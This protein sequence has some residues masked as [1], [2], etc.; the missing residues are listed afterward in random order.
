MKRSIWLVPLVAVVLVA[1]GTACGGDRRA[2]RTTETDG[3]S[4]VSE[5]SRKSTEPPGSGPTDESAGTDPADLTETSKQDLSPIESD[6]AGIDQDLS[7]FD[8]HLQEANAELGHADET[9][10]D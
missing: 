6:L 1:L 5:A 2:A 4:L 9:D 10:V 3:T 7:E 8:S